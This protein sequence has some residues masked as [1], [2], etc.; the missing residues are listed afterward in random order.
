LGKAKSRL[1]EL[2]Q[3]MGVMSLVEQH[4][5]EAEASLEKAAKPQSC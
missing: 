4:A 1:P 5:T 2:Y 3:Q